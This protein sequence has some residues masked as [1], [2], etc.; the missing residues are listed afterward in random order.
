MAMDLNNDNFKEELL[1]SDKIV[2][3]DFWATWCV[4]CRSLAPVYDELS[5]EMPLLKFCKLNIDGASDISEEYGV[6][7]IPCII[8][9]KGGKEIGR[10][11]GSM[12]KKELESKINIIIGKKYSK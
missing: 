10:I 9:F 6:R 3:V 4:P 8:I 2:L 11:V 1:D 5:K 7:G 12:G